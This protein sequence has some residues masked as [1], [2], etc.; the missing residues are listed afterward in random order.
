[1]RP[2][3]RPV[4]NTGLKVLLL[5]LYEVALLEQGGGGVRGPCRPPLLPLPPH[6]PV[7][8]CT[9]LFILLLL[10]L[11]AIRLNECM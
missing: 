10:L 8:E 11:A 6:D 9:L 3:S 4:G 5:I 1:M 2:K 7:H